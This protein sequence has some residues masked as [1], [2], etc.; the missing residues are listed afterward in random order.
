MFVSLAGSFRTILCAAILCCCSQPALAGFVLTPSG[1]LPP[2]GVAMIRWEGS[3]RPLKT[4]ITFLDTA[5]PVYADGGD[6]HALIGIDME[7]SPGS[8]PVTITAIAASGEAIET[9]LTLAVTAVERPAERLTLPKQMAT[10]TA[11]KI[12]K[13]IEQE[14]K[15]LGK[16][17]AVRSAKLYWSDFIV[18]VDA[19]VGSPFGLRRIL[20]GVEKSPHNGVDFRAGAG[21]P[22]RAAAG[23]RVALAR[24]LYYTGKTVII[25]HGGGLFSL[26]AHLQAITVSQ[27]RQV[28][29]GDL[30][31]EVGSTG[32]STG[33]HLHFGTRLGGARVD[34]LALIGLFS[35]VRR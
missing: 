2:G 8:Y 25:D 21:L 35:T 11:P 12:L 17:F 26:Y 1:D 28:T 18:P 15:E 5:V 22:V 32:R 16:V 20:N 3:D 6:V 29:A 30:V 10:P 23:G 14:R 24:D 34:P 13:R 7:T 33:P 31:G 19:E 9:R 27:G 4:R